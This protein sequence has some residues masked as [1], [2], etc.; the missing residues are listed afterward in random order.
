MCDIN[1]GIF[2]VFIVSNVF[3][4]LFSPYSGSGLPCGFSSLM[5]LRIA[6][7][8]SVCSAFYLLRMVVS[9]F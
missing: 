8:F 3:L 5:D 6:V 1:S 7:D 9:S 4:F 2:L